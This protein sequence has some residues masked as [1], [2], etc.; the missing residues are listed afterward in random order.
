MECEAFS[1]VLK[2]K[3]KNLELGKYVAVA[4]EETSQ[5]NTQGYHQQMYV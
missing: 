5:K 2:R 3:R 1:L 4:M